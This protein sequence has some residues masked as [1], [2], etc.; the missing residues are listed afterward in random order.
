MPTLPL[1]CWTTNCDPPTAN[2]W[3]LATVVVPVVLVNAPR[4]KYPVPLTVNAVELAY[5]NT[6]AVAP[7]AMK[8]D[9]VGVEVAV[10]LPALSV[11]SSVLVTPGSQRVPIVARDE[12]ELTAVRRPATVD[13]AWDMKPPANVPRELSDNDR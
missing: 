13:E 6:E 5:G 1:P 12:E 9:A 3:P 4:P 7:V 8:E 2:P 10:S 11:D